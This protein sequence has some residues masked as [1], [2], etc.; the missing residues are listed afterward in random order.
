MRIIKVQRGHRTDGARP[1]SS[2]LT[3]RSSPQHGGQ[4]AERWR[5]KGNDPTLTQKEALIGNFHDSQSM[6][7][8]KPPTEKAGSHQSLSFSKIWDLK[9]IPKPY[10]RGQVAKT[11]SS[12]TDEDKSP[13]NPFS[14]SLSSSQTSGYW[15]TPRGCYSDYKE[16]NESPAVGAQSTWRG[17]QSSNFLSSTSRLTPHATSISNGANTPVINTNPSAEKLTSSITDSPHGR[18]SMSNGQTQRHKKMQ[19]YLFKGPETSVNRV[20][21]DGREALSGQSNA[22]I[23]SDNQRPSDV[24]AASRFGSRYYN[25][26]DT[27]K[28]ITSNLPYHHTSA[29]QNDEQMHKDLKRPISSLVLPPH[30]TEQSSD[31]HLAPVKT[32]NMASFSPSP[33]I[34]STHGYATRSEEPLSVSKVNATTRDLMPIQKPGG[35]TQSIFGFKEFKNPVW[36]AV[37]KPRALTFKEQPNS[38]LHSFENMKH[39]K[40]KMSNFYPALL[41]RYSFGQRGGSATTTMPPVMLEKNP[42]VYSSPSPSTLIPVT[43]PTLFVSGFMQVMTPKSD[44]GVDRN[45]NY[46]QFRTY[47]I[48]KAPK[49]S[50]SRPLEGAK[51]SV[52]GPDKSARLQ[53]DLDGIK[54]GR[55]QTSEPRSFSVDLKPYLKTAED[56]VLVLPG[57]NSSRPYTFRR[58]KSLK[59]TTAQARNKIWWQYPMQ[60]PASASYIVSSAYLRSAGRLTFASKQKSELRT[61]NQSKPAE[62]KATLLHTSTSR[63]VR[64]KHSKARHRHRNSKKLGDST[65]T[66][67]TVAIVRLPKRPAEVKAVTYTDVL[68]SAS[69]SGVMETTESPD[70]PTDMD[71]FPNV[72]AT[73]E[74]KKAMN[75]SNLNSDDEY[76]G[77]NMTKNSEENTDDEMGDFSGTEKNKADKSEK[78]D[79]EWKKTDFFPDNEESGGSEVLSSVVGS[80]AFTKDLL[81]MEYLRTSTENVSFKSVLTQIKKQ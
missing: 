4:S 78:A 60:D 11:D 25:T 1:A 8:R 6:I 19:A 54:V 43:T 7:I 20:V 15:E 2:S 34:Y 45:L 79:Y 26:K 40:F 59:N 69:F 24:P 3:S 41:Q 16:T 63:S 53:Q 48:T 56:S 57:K 67:H 49:R 74:Q 23:T 13:G 72:T 10:S 55:R 30:I 70:R 5:S 44:P 14:F 21:G 42:V 68:G 65:F 62:M 32:K 27:T 77:K 47:K 9:Y 51:P 64:A 12:R 73:T 61:P 58:F 71:H 28:Q 37:K 75:R 31:L 38:K 22:F 36:Q 17:S 66:N 35:G 81:E 46:R 50:D 39:Y 80:Q 33:H 76:S 52:Q 18:D 29:A